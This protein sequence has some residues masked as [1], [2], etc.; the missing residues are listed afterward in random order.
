MDFDENCT[1]CGGTKVNE[2][3]DPMTD[4]VTRRVV[5]IGCHGTGKRSEPWQWTDRETGVEVTARRA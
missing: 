4:R 5:C 3:V 1:D 2:C